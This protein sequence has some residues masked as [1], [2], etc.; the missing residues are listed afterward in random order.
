M[1]VQ[2]YSDA[3]DFCDRPI[4]VTPAQGRF[5]LQHCVSVGL[6]KG[7]VS[8]SDFTENRLHD[9]QIEALRK[10]VRICEDPSF[11]QAYP[12]HF[13]SAVKVMNSNGK[14]KTVKIADAKGD[15]EWPL[16][17]EDLLKKFYDLAESGGADS[18]RVQELAKALLQSPLSTP[19]PKI[20][21]SAP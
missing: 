1:V 17:D 19:L 10:N 21:L 18:S 14:K 13:G 11:T 3:I 9:S 4:P 8:S 12:N 20:L 5:S 16:K 6:L 15:P 2:T 7:D